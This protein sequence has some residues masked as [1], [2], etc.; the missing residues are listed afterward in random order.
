VPIFYNSLRPALSVSVEA[1]SHTGGIL[2]VVSASLLEALAD[3]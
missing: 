2:V 1:L 3:V